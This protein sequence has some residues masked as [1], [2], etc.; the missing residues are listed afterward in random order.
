[1]SVRKIV[2]A[3]AS[4]LEKVC[5]EVSVYN[6][7]LHR[8]IDDMIDTMYAADGVGLAAP[9]I[10]ITE[11]IAVVDVDDEHGCIELIN[12]III[13]FS[14]EQI[15]PEGCLSIPDVFGDVKRHMDIKVQ[16]NDRYGKTFI[17]DAEGFQARAIQHEID[18]LNGIL[19][20]TKVIRYYEKGEFER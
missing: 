4:E 5:T 1:M 14:G 19:F 9:Q 15:G 6:K 18:H 3:P 13:S 12:P 8:L 2:Y 16:A 20:T 11:R 17:I 7:K 10:G